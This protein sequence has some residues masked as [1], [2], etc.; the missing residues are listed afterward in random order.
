VAMPA[1]KELPWLQP[2]AL[3]TQQTSFSNRNALLL[4]SNQLEATSDTQ[5]LTRN[6]D[7]GIYL[8]NAPKSQAI[9]G[10]I[11]GSQYTTSY[12]QTNISTNNASVVVQS[13]DDNIIDSSDKL[14]ISIGTRS[15]PKAG[16]KLPYYVEPISGE[17]TIRAKPGLKAYLN[18]STTLSAASPTTATGS[19]TG[20]TSPAGSTDGTGAEPVPATY[21]MTYSEG[22]YQI[23]FDGTAIVTWLTL[24]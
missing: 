24:K 12:L 10:F 13:L 23:K 3:G 6:W 11:G 20:A 7:K 21:P 22:K 16:A 5:E 19:S 18:T 2:S 15:E 14:L 9:I 8:V 17:I 1:V 4:N